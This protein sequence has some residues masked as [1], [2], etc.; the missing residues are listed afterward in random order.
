[1]YGHCA[2]PHPTTTVA[3]APIDSSRA[4]RVGPPQSST[5]DPIPQMRRQ[6]HE[7][8]RPR[9]EAVEEVPGVGV[10]HEDADERD[11]AGDDPGADGR[12][13][14]S[15]RP[16]SASSEPLRVPH[17]VHRREV[18]AHGDREHAAERSTSG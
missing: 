10:E 9:R 2:T 15:T 13:D 11:D 6:D 18:R 7:R 5:S 14:G 8:Q 17:E 4:P 1:M 16:S 3:T 12:A